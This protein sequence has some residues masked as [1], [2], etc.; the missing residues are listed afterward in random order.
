MAFP[1][2]VELAHEE[3]SDQKGSKHEGEDEG[4]H[5]ERF[6]DVFNKIRK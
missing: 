4:L 6:G 2:L 5:G 3:G 1:S